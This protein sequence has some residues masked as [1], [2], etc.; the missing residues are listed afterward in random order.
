MTPI[1]AGSIQVSTLSK[2]QKTQEKRGEKYQVVIDGL[3]T[4]QNV[5]DS[6]R[7]SR[8]LEQHTVELREKLHQGGREGPY[9]AAKLKMP[10]IVPA[11]K[12]PSG[13]L[14]DNLPPAEWHNGLYGYDI[15]ENRETLDLP[16][17]RSALID[18]PGVVMVGTSCAGDALYAFFAGPVAVDKADYVRRWTAISAAMPTAAQAASGAASKN[19]NRIRFMAHDPDVWLASGPVTP[20]SGAVALL[21]SAATPAPPLE[22]EHRIDLAALEAIHPPDGGGD[23]DY[24]SWLGWLGTLKTLGFSVAETE[25]WSGRG[26]NYRAGEVADRWE[27]LPS[28]AHEDARNKL[29]GAAYN[30]GWRRSAPAALARPTPAAAPRPTPP[31]SALSPTPIKDAAPLSALSPWFQSVEW[32]YRT[33]GKGRWVYT[34]EHD[35]AGWWR[36]TDHVW[37]QVSS[38]DHAMADEWLINRYQ[39]AAELDKMGYRDPAEALTRGKALPESLRSPISELW[40]ALRHVCLHPIPKSLPHQVGTPEGV[41]DIRTGQFLPHHHSL[42]MRALTVGRFLPGDLDAHQAALTRR[43]G[44]VFDEPTIHEFVRL[45]GLALS[46]EAQSHRSLVMVKGPSGSGKGDCINVLKHALGRRALGAGNEWISEGPRSEIDVTGHDILL[47]EPAILAVDE[48]GSATKVAVPRLL[49]LTGNSNWAKRRPYGYLLQGKPRFQMWTTAVDT[50]RM[51]R[52]LGVERRLAVLKTQRVLEEYE[53]DEKGGSAPELLNAVVTLGLLAAR[54]VFAPRYRAPAGSE[55]G[56]DSILEGM[57]PLWAWLDL[58]D[59]LDGMGVGDARL[60]AMKALDLD[61]LSSKAFGMT[62]ELSGRWAVK[63]TKTGNVLQRR[64]LPLLPS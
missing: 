42:G 35:G 28:D 15:D 30:L 56:K 54:E 2:G 22:D 12:A 9:K 3:T 49:S 14:L 47:Y 5:V 44:P 63:H 21:P 10:A 33:H 7:T 52:G 36:Y 53:K 50:P 57:D 16:S 34:D 31:A 1:N 39:Y 51:R 45:V 25:K 19:P 6:I 40:A 27:S 62:V 64:T 46:G 60:M 38:E 59:D 43:F 58:Q 61:K 37:R 48:V 26:K 29:R 13:T 4:L 41:Y 20:L 32:W 23:K 55:A 17:L 11:A 8:N 24:N 18:T